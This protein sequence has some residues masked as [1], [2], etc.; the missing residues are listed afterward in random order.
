MTF[1]ARFA[2]LVVICAYVRRS[3]AMWLPQ[4]LSL[5]LPLWLLTNISGDLGSMNPNPSHRKGAEK[6]VR[7]MPASRLCKAESQVLLSVPEEVTL[8]EWT[9]GNLTMASR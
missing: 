4:Q 6:L 5:L 7:D 9:S 2:C 1:L 8:Q 3:A